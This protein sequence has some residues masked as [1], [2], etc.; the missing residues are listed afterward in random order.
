MLMTK[1]WLVATI[2]AGLIGTVAVG[3]FAAGRGYVD[4]KGR[5]HGC[6]GK[7]GVLSVVKAGGN[8]PKHT[9]DLVFDQ[10]GKRGPAGT[11]APLQWIAVQPKSGSDFSCDPGAFCGYLIDNWAN[12]GNNFQAVGYSKDSADVVRLRGIAVGPAL[13][14]VSDACSGGQDAAIFDLPTGYR[15]AVAERFLVDAESNATEAQVRVDVEPDG[16]VS[17]NDPDHP[18]TGENNGY[19]D[20]SGISFSAG[21]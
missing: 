3:S 9:K 18:D 2:T 20:L 14:E 12:Y 6:V 4:G 8:C 10:Q 19:V 5:I 11:V 15:P 21:G 16:V 17:C 13:T 7:H 1:P